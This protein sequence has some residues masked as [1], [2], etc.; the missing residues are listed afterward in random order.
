M[1]D[2]LEACRVIEQN[3]NNAIVVTTMGAGN[4]RFGWPVV[5]QDEALDV[6]VG[7]AMGKASSFA[8]GLALAQPDRNVL[9]LDGDG[10]LVM[11][12]GHP[13]HHQRDG[14]LQPLSFRL[15]KRMLRRHR[16]TAYPRRW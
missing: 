1:I 4:P 14:A 11:N 3:R 7:G 5:S 15:R 6:P 12:L 10:S 8:L 16:R 9:I 13:Y 2:N